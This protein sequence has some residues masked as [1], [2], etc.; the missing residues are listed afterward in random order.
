MRAP[1]K[2]Y[3]F[4]DGI[5]LSDHAYNGADLL[6]FGVPSGVAGSLFCFDSVDVAR[7]PNDST[8]LGSLA[9]G[10]PVTMKVWTPNGK[11]QFF[12]LADEQDVARHRQAACSRRSAEWRAARSSR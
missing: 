4:R 3:F 5:E 1:M 11:P 2:V 10:G 8:T 12:G 7:G 6:S 9:F